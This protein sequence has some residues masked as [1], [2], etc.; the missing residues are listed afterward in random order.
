MTLE[1]VTPEGAKV[2]NLAVTDVTLPSVMGEMGILPGHVPIMAALGI[3]PLVA[4]TPEGSKA[5]AISG[6]YVEVLE[7]R[8]NVLSETCEAAADI[9]V[10]RA[11]AKLASATARLAGMTAA[12]GEAYQV[13]L[14]SVR[15][16]ETRLKVAGVGR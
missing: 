6:G 13:V 16:A 9:D 1:V 5:F 7:D 3:G 10:E 8:V 14:A 12:E 2:R 4:G 11:R 15:K